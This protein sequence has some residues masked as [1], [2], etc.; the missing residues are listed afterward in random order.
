M[1][2]LDHLL[3]SDPEEGRRELAR[4]LARGLLRLR[5]HLP[6]PPEVSATQKSQHSA[7][8]GLAMSAKQSVTVIQG[9]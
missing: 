9:G 5:G 4:I 6:K 8:S 2:P 7:S 1:R 3:P